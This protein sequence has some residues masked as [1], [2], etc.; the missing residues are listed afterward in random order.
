MAKLTSLN[1]A[2][3]RD[4]KNWIVPSGKVWKDCMLSEQYTD[5]LKEHTPWSL[6]TMSAVALVSDNWSY[7]I[8]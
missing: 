7:R 5:V 2:S 1:K 8:I 6:W 3:Q 4:E